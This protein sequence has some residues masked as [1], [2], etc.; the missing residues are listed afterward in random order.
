MARKNT[1]ENRL[2]RWS[3]YL[4]ETIFSLFWIYSFYSLATSGPSY[5]YGLSYNIAWIL[6]LWLPFLIAHLAAYFTYGRRPDTVE[7]ER[8]VYRE[9]FADGVREQAN[10]RD[11]YDSRHLSTDYPVEY[12][13]ETPEPEKRKREVR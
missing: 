10:L 11:I 4:H 3:L 8:K 13:S 12:L 7:I 5:T 1:L 2:W 6:L 9:G